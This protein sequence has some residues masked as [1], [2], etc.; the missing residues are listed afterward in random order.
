MRTRRAP[1]ALLTLPQVAGFAPEWSSL[2]RRTA[3][4][5]LVSA[6]RKHEIKTHRRQKELLK[7]SLDENENC[8][9]E[10]EH[11]MKCTPSRLRRPCGA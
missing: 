4:L 10:K 11:T 8:R 2:P 9:D 5:P 7:N 1:F 3:T 6:T